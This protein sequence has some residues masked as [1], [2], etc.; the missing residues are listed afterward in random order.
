[1][2]ED[3]NNKCYICNLDRETVSVSCSLVGLIVP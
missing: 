3:M 2:D 1:M